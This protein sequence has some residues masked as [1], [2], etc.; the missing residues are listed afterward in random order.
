MNYK[1]HK[2][3]R[4]SET[5]YSKKY[6]LDCDSESGMTLKFWNQFLTFLWQNNKICAAMVINV[7]QGVSDPF[8]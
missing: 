7:L 1:V 8:T 3:R 6:T 4:V 5:V 2:V